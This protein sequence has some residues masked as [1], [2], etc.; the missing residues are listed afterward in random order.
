MQVVTL[1]NITLQNWQSEFVEQKV[2]YDMQQYNTFICATCFELRKD[3]QT[4]IL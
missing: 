1:D 2:L 3:L 4:N